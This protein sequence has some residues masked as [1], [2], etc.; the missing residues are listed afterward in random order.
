MATIDASNH[1]RKQGAHHNLAAEEGIVCNSKATW[2][3]RAA[4]LIDRTL[5]TYR[6]R[7]LQHF[8][9]HPVYLGIALREGAVPLRG[10]GSDVC[11]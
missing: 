10:L 5:E 7:G 4:L 11:A 8:R 2:V 1:Q 6:G 3:I 9:M